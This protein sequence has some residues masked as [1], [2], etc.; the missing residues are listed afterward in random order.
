M[1]YTGHVGESSVSQK[2][3]G[4]GEPRSPI[5]HWRGGGLSQCIKWPV[6]CPEPVASILV[7][8]KQRSFVFVVGGK[9]LENLIEFGSH[10]P[11]SNDLVLLIFFFFFWLLE[12]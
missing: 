1:R 5:P 11:R 10:A 12:I 2:R 8:T 7:Q 4:L 9:S 6:E 3:K